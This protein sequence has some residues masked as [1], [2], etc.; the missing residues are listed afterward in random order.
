MSGKNNLQVSVTRGD[1]VESVH[2]AVVAVAGP[3]GALTASAGDPDF[4]AYFRS[5]AKPFQ[6][7]PLVSSGAADAF[8][9]TDSELAFC[10][11]SHNA[12]SG[13]QLAVQAML[14]KIGMG[15]SQLQCG[16]APPLDEEENARVLLGLVAPS[17]LQNCCSGKHTGMLA[18]CRHLGYPV[19]TYLS[20]DHPLQRQI[21]EL[22]AEAMQRDPASIALAADGCSVP[23]FGASVADFAR[24]FAALAAPATAPSELIRSHQVTIERLLAVMSRYPDNIAGRG[25]LDTELMRLSN[26]TIAAKL[27]AEGLLCMALPEQGVGIA[28]RMCDGTYRGLNILAVEVLGQLG[29]VEPAALLAMEASLIEPIKNANGWVVGQFTTNLA[30]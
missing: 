27:G 29:L 16:A 28:I 18:T 23:T 10:C 25:S 19:E 9:F 30:L 22:V 14:Q 11:S 3:D 1:R 6:A 26:G 12:D 4:F 17:A 20:A 7:I 24:A 13:Q 2:Q 21:L 8:G 15:V 5:S